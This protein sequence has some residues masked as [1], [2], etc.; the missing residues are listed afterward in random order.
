MVAA[1]L[2]DSTGDAVEMPFQDGGEQRVT[3]RIVLIE[4]A[5]RHAGAHGDPRRRAA[6]QTLAGQNL[7]GRD[8]QGVDGRRRAGLNRRF[9]G[10]QGRCDGAHGMRIQN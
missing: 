4:A 1:G 3:I 8:V 9:P 5:D 6:A 2:L 7:N 10:L